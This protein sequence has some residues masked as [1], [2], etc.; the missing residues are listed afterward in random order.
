MTV[1]YVTAGGTAEEGSDYTRTSGTLTFAPGEDART[2]AVLTLEDEVDE[3]NETFTLDL[4]NPDGATIQDGTAT[5]TI[6]D[7]DEPPVIVITD[8]EA[9]EGE[10]AEF[11]V[12]LSAVTSRTVTID[13]ATAGGTAEE[14]SDYTATSGTLTFAPGEDARTIAVLTLED[15]VDE[16]NETFT[17][18]L[19]NPDGATIQ[20]GTATGTINDDDETP[21]IVITDAE[22]EE[23]EIAEFTVTLSAITSRTVTVDYAT[24]GGTAEEGSDYATTSGTLTFAPG[25]D[26]KTIPVPTLEDELDEENETF[27]LDLGNPGAATIQDGTATGTINDDDEPPVIV[28]TDAEAEEGEPAEFTITLSAVTS[29][30]VTIDYATAGGTAEEGSDYTRTFGTLTFVPGE[31]AKTLAVLTLEDEIDE[32]NET[33]TLDLGNPDN[34]TI[35]DGAATG[36]II[37]DDEPIIYIADAEAREGDA[38]EFLVTLWPAGDETVTVSFH[39]VDGTA[40]AGLDYTSTMGTLR[41]E[42]GETS[43]T[44]AVSALTDELADDSERFTLELSD[45]V[46]ATVG[47]AT[48]VGIITDDPTARI[49]A[50]NRIILPEVGRALAFNAVR[51]RFDRPISAA[52]AGNGTRRSTGHLSLSHGLLAGRRISPTDPWNSPAGPWNSPAHTSLT[53]EQA[54]GNSSFLMPAAIGEGGTGRYT[55]WGCADYYLLAGGRNAPLSWNGA[56]FSAQI[57]ADVALSSNTLAGVAVS[58]SRSA[59]HYTGLGGGA[60]DVGMNVLRLTGVN[61]YLAW[62]VTPQLDVWGT[63]GHAWGQLQIDD[64][65]GAGSLSSVATLNSGMVGVNGRLLARDGTTLRLRGE[66][67][68]AHLGIAGDG[69]MMSAVGLDM[70]RVRLSTEASYQHVFPFEA[71]LTPWGELGLRHDGGDGETGAGLEV[72]AGLRYRAVPQGLTIEGYGRRL[73]VHE[74]AVRESGFGLLLRVD[75]GDS[76]FGPSMSLTPAWGATTSGVNQL[77]ERGANAFSM[78]DTPGA[79]M[80]ARFAYGLPALRGT[81][82]LTPFGMLSLAGEDGRAYGLGATLAVRRTASLSLEAERRR[83]LAARAIYAVMLRGMLQF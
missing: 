33:F 10:P 76:G 48:G 64:K 78:Y 22:A 37:D 73:V 65:L 14:G 74:G 43:A 41:F 17:L 9:E 12:T 29:R 30:T 81:G 42:P 11:T 55:A 23:G 69:D 66:G 38:A 58:R 54:L 67:G 34:A 70:H 6:N 44:I 49:E 45:P 21:V 68:L 18:D 62:S 8:A 82:L 72:R 60:D 51:C 7:D 77:W 20:D 39:T 56:A 1:D 57:G 2:I 50:V 53:L 4:S 35:Q 25:E 16:R 59:F 83:R 79:R 5:G 71:T 36:T 80:N 75:P 27:T 13:Y 26:A 15:E 52:P 47:D 40:V 46:E 19:S 24:A 32:R 3:R 31:D 63:V 61:P 28:I